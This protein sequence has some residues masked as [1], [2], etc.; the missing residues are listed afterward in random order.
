ML[1][2]YSVIL[3]I[4]I[5]LSFTFLIIILKL[6]DKLCNNLTEVTNI[7]NKL[8]Q[9]TNWITFLLSSLISLDTL[10]TI[11]NEEKYNIQYN[12]YLDSI[13]DY[14]YTLKNLS[15]T[16]IERIGTNF[17][18]VEKA[19][20]TFTKES[21]NLFWEKEEILDYYNLYESYEPYPFALYQVL[22]NAKILIDEPYF[23]SVILYDTK[24]SYYNNKSI[25]SK[26]IFRTIFHNIKCIKRN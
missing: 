21:R 12:I 10:Y 24:L 18:L 13:S 25:I 17:S 11:K 16:W 3:I 15:L 22:T 2:Y 7:N 5:S 8:Y 20:A 1:K 26:I 19:I 23:T 4:I 14:V 9:T 6:F